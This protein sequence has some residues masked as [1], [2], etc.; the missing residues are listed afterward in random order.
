MCKAG[1]VDEAY[2]TAKS[3]LA[4][5][6]QDVCAQ[7]EVAWAL[8]YMLKADMVSK[9]G[10]AFISHLEE[11][12]GLNLI[13]PT[14]DVIIFKSILWKLAG[15]IKNIPESNVGEINKLFSIFGK[16]SFA[17][18]K[19]YSYLLSSCLHFNTWEH[20]T[21]FLEW[22]DLDNLLLEDYQPYMSEQGRKI[23]S[24]AERAYIAYSKA[25]L[26]LDDKDRIRQFLPKIEKLMDD[27]PDMMYPGYFCGKLMLATGVAGEDALN[28]VMPFV[29]KKQSEFWIWQ[30]LAEIYKQDTDKCLACLLRAVHCKAKEEF[31]GKVR[32]RLASVY[33]FHKDYCRAKFQI[34][35]IVQCYSKQ[36]WH[37][38]KDVQDWVRESWMNDAVADGSDGI[39][40]Y[41]R[42]TNAILSHGTNESIA[43]VVYVNDESKRAT[44][45][46]GEE[47]RAV[48]KLH[49]LNV[50]VTE[51]TL[52]KIHWLLGEKEGINVVSA[53]LIGPEMQ[54]TAY[55][56]R[57]NGTV[58]K[59]ADKPFAFIKGQGIDCFI[60][61]A[62]VQKYSLKGG[63]TASVL[64]VYNYNKKKEKWTWVCLS[65]KCDK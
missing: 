31:L 22:W 18:S 4:E 7:R 25:L 59:S 65:I 23:M 15:F 12:A 55:I 53:E 50:K 43:V 57:I 30:L 51:G 58:M 39:E 52:L 24:L 47:K 36:G 42:I 44:V 26:R 40:D 17:P 62:M 60:A 2:Q 46:Y 6:P 3:D 14:I 34:D 16:Y 54:D 63:E 49:S 33:I 19:E 64:A 27:H 5:A 21:D 41:K 1:N 48:L 9:D 32:I 13:T 56:K 28:K 35:K 45:V 38:P 10:S 29:R 61:P 37:L 11:V 8:Y 20:L